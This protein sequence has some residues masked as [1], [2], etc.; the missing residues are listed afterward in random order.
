MTERKWFPSKFLLGGIV[1]LLITTLVGAGLLFFHPG[2]AHAA[3]LMTCTGTVSLG[4]SPPMTNT[5]T[6]ITVTVDSTWTCD[7]PNNSTLT[8]GNHHVVLTDNLLAC[9]E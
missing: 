2:K 4:Y 7:D 8:G 9:D 3:T 6:N 5:P 1:A